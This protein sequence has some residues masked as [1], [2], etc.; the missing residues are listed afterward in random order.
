MDMRLASHAVAQAE[1]LKAELRALAGDDE[2]AVRDTLDGAT[3]IESI[4]DF[5]LL[6]VGEDEATILGIKDFLRTIDARKKRIENRIDALRKLGLKALELRGDK[7]VRRPLGTM[8]VQPKAP[9]I[10]DRTLDESRVPAKF[11]KKP[12]PVLSRSALLDALK[13]GEVVPGASLAPPSDTLRI[14]RK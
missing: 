7:V 8:T 13:A 2:D 12:D 4:L 6:Q 14:N 3:D 9:A 11:W 5:I 1:A 10:D